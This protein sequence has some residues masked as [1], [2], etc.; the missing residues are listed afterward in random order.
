MH[1]NI[2]GALINSALYMLCAFAAGLVTNHPLAWKLA[3]AAMGVAF[4][5]HLISMLR[6]S[7]L[8]INVAECLAV[9]SWLLGAASGIALLF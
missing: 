5:T 2:V 9:I 1:P 7:R 6:D 8:A 3:L 4:F